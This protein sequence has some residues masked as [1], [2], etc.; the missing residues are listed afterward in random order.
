MACSSTEG[1]AGYA[2][3]A[4][5]VVSLALAVV[6]AAAVQSSTSALRLARAELERTRIEYEL[7]GA[8][9]RAISSAAATGGAKR[10]SWSFPAQSGS[11]R[12][13][14]E[15]QAT[16]LP[17]AKAAGSISATLFDD[18]R[19]VSPDKL[20]SRLQIMALNSGGELAALPDADASPQWRRCAASLISRYG[21]AQKAALT[22]TEPPQPGR[23]FWRAGEVWRVRVSSAG[24]VDDRIVRI[25]G[26]PAHP[27]AVIE[28]RFYRGEGEGQ[29]D[30]LA[31]T[32][33]G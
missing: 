23:A 5:T 18:L 26:D 27:A 25:T 14:A 1:E 11:V 21:Q 16:K 22:R 3:A 4:A 29:C 28:R 12:A 15:P 32:K 7:S 10:L 33:R 30:T 31:T 8:S 2:T 20:R 9:L 6:A 13:L 24:W 17:L 19:V